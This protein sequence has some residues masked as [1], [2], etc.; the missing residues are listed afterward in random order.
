MQQSSALLLPAS[1]NTHRA[2]VMENKHGAAGTAKS[3]PMWPA[4][5]HPLQEDSAPLSC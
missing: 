4:E 2:A 1:G 3:R 5:I